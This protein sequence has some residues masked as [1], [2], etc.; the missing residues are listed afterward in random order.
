MKLKYPLN[1]DILNSRLQEV[2]KSLK[3]LK[4]LRG[5]FPTNEYAAISAQLVDQGILPKKFKSTAVKMA[6]YR[7]RLVH[8]YHEISKEELFEILKSHLSDLEDFHLYLLRFAQS[9]SK[10]WRFF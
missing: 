6:K 8:F 10:D 7:N 4:E 5:E 9:Q 2:E 1:L 3:R